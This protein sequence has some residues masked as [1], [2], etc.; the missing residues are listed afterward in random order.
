MMYCRFM[1]QFRP[2]PV[3]FKKSFLAVLACCLCT[4]LLI[5]SAE[6][7]PKR[8]TSNKLIKKSPKTG[9]PHSVK[10][11]GKKRALSFGAPQTLLAEPQPQETGESELRGVASFYGKGFQ[12]RKSASGERFDHRKMT[13]AS[14]RFA[15]GTW[16]AVRRLDSELCVVV[17]V[18]DRM[19]AKHR[20]R[21][22]DLSRGA[23]ERLN[24]ISAGLIMVR[25]VP[26]AGVPEGDDAAVCQKAFALTLPRPELETVD[27]AKPPEK[28]VEELPKL[29]RVEPL[30]VPSAE[31]T[32]V[33]PEQVIP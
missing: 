25:A 10:S 3:F 32:G 8:T 15:L 16:L 12:G 33:V 14:N 6:A 22:I 23:A 31:K 2:G 20:V 5:D 11:A 29:P 4:S 19:H 24:M 27:Q 17:K 28:T 13:A 1:D 18:N 26:L 7:R 21:I 30:E 9:A